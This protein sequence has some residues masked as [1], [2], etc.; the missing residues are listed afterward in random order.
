VQPEARV[1]TPALATRRGGEP[2]VPWSTCYF[3]HEKS[4]FLF[5]GDLFSTFFTLL[6]F[7]KKISTSFIHSSFSFISFSSE[8]VPRRLHSDDDGR[9]RQI[10]AQSGRTGGLDGLDV[11]HQFDSRR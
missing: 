7:E 11:S 6:V 2:F 3:F 10:V 9:R 4:N 8:Q 5:S 1:T